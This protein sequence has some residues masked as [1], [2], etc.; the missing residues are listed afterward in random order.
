VGGNEED[1][2]GDDGWQGHGQ[3]E[4][5]RV[6]DICGCSGWQAVD[7]SEAPPPPSPQPRLPGCE[8]LPAMDITDKTKPLQR[9][10]G[11]STP[12][13]SSKRYQQTN[14]YSR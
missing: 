11:L 8:S 14:Y 10:S 7:Q 12:T 2:D 5:V 4:I 3:S 6:Y 1:Q 9:F 13:S